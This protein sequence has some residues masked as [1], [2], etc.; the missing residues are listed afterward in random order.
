MAS[1]SADG[2]VDAVVSADLFLL[3]AAMLPAINK[4]NVI[5]V[6]KEAVKGCFSVLKRGFN[7][8]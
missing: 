3:Q 6:K 4:P 1:L 8:P 2:G 5:F 7:S